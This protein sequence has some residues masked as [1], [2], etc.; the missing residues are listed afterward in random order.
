MEV[1]INWK[2]PNNCKFHVTRPRS[3]KCTLKGNGEG[4]GGELVPL[5]SRH[6][7]PN[8]VSPLG[9]FH[10]HRIIFHMHYLMQ[11]VTR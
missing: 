7:A 10:V 6:H 9:I 8:R 1:T 5:S 3:A 11:E 2:V 4:L